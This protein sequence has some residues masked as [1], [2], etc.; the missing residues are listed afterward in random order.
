MKIDWSKWT[1]TINE[2]WTDNAIAMNSETGVHVNLGK[3]EKFKNEDNIPQ[4]IKEKVKEGI[5]KCYIE[6][7]IKIWKGQ[8]IPV[9]DNLDY[10]ENE[11]EKRGLV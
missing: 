4:V 11:A 7:Q 5:R 3:L 9:E 2:N 8:T 10:I 1:F 6:E